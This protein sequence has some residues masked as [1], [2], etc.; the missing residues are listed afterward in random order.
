MYCTYIQYIHA[1]L[2]GESAG[3][4]VIASLRNSPSCSN[5]LRLEKEDYPQAEKA[6]ATGY[7]IEMSDLSQTG[8]VH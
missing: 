4:S 2:T 5:V 6:S 3:P 1:V 8:R 7:S